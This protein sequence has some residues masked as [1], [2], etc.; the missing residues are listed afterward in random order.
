MALTV[1]RQVLLATGFIANNFCSP[2][3]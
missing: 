3:W 2:N 1:H